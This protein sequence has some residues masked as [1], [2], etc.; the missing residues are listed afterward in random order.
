MSLPAPHGAPVRDYATA[1]MLVRACC[2]P[3]ARAYVARELPT[4]SKSLSGRRRAPAAGAAGGGAAVGRRGGGRAAPAGP[5][6]HVAGRRRRRRRRA[7]HVQRGRVRATPTLGRRSM[8][9]RYA[10]SAPP[11]GRRASGAHIPRARRAL[12]RRGPPQSSRRPRS[13]GSRA[14]TAPPPR[15]TTAH[16][17]ARCSDSARWSAATRLLGPTR[18]PPSG[19]TR[20]APSSSR[21]D[22]PRGCRDARLRCSSAR[23][24]HCSRRDRPTWRV[25]PSTR[26]CLRWWRWAT[27]TVRGA[28]TRRRARRAC[29]STLPAPTRSSARA[30]TP[31]VSTAP[32]RG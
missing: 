29:R 16:A 1:S 15:S 17:R 14:P 3:A 22:A 4:A 12:D 7:A 10:A 24:R 27:P 6:P 9:S 23:S 5:R 13:G 28:L 2:T 18:R 21:A 11:A 8:A 32:G 19:C 25:E 20:R 31:S 30:A 26:G